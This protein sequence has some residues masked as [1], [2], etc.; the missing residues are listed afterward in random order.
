[1][2]NLYVFAIG[3]S[4]SRVI[5]ALT[6]LLAS[7][8]KMKDTDA[9]IPI[10]IDP[11]TANADL[12]RT[13]EIIRLYNKIRSKSEQ[14]E[15]TF[16]NAN[17][18]SLDE[19]G[20]DGTSTSVYRFE[21]DGVKNAKFRN[22]IDYSS[23]SKNNQA[24]T[25]LLFS[26]NNLESS[27]EVG[28]K[29]NPN[30]GSV[31]LNKMKDSDFFQKF[32]SAFQQNDRIFI[33]SS[34]FGGTGAAGFPLLLKNIRDANA[35]VSNHIFLQNAMIGAISL[36]PYF[37]VTK[38][39]KSSVSI[40]SDTFITKTK[41][42][43]SYYSRTVTNDGSVN[44]LYY[45]GDNTHNPQKGSD[46]GASQQNNAHFVEMIAAYAIINFM[47]FSNDDLQVVN[48]RAIAPK[49]MEYGL[50]EESNK[51]NFKYLAD[52]TRKRIAMPL[53]QFAL[54][55]SFL[56]N[57][58]S[59][60]A[61]KP[62]AIGGTKKLTEEG[63]DNTFLQGLRK[64]HNSY[65]LWLDEMEKSEVKFKPLDCSKKGDDLLNMVENYQ[66]PLSLIDKLKDQGADHIVHSLNDHARKLDF[67]TNE[68]K[69][70]AV[71]SK[72]TRQAIIDKTKLNLC[73]KFS[74]YTQ[75]LIIQ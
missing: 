50:N 28:F 11:D 10:I 46:G 58:F 69:L 47:D 30:I 42:A 27:M 74:G 23:L 48:R 39:D 38:D 40:N 68:Q 29:G 75:V 73:P 70:L 32:A 41:A 21:L 14:V 3:G 66:K 19:M 61:G 37:D 20:V 67:L 49:F 26:K 51:V 65:D 12:S 45:I 54:F 36:L 56:K 7:G 34:I 55:S 43:L 9:V 35:S 24:F 8:V 18:R 72:A 2:P 6:M 62:W 5:K 4:G 52:D 60:Y 31:V 44:A 15:N 64:F 16:F 57:H 33:I 22:Y 17:I 25:S 1:M 53:T 71:F 13:V 59:Q 63:L